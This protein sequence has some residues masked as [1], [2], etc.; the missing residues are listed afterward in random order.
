MS[1]FHMGDILLGKQKLRACVSLQ[2]DASISEA[3]LSQGIGKQCL[4]E[5]LLTDS[6]SVL[7][8]SFPIYYLNVNIEFLSAVTDLALFVWKVCN[9]EMLSLTRL[10]LNPLPYYTG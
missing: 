7:Y 4:D 10:L 3:L 2:I 6:R 9:I 5:T 8:F 1:E